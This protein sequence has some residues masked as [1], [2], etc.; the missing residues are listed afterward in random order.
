MKNDQP[1]KLVE[2]VSIILNKI[3]RDF[4]AY[5][6]VVEFSYP[7]VSHA[8]SLLD[9]AIV[10]LLQQIRWDVVTK[11]IPLFRRPSPCEFKATSVRDV[12]YSGLW[13]SLC[14]SKNE[15]QFLYSRCNSFYISFLYRFIIR[16][17]RSF[18]LKQPFSPYRHTLT[19]TSKFF[20]PLL[21]EFCIVCEEKYIL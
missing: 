20:P 2:T 11:Q 18:E 13:S 16:Q 17:L 15:N 4:S 10:F 5:W 19:H 14:V 7:F 6:L 3:L 21:S 8:V 9:T 1:I 12:E